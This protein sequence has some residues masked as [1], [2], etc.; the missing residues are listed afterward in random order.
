MIYLFH[1]RLPA[2]LEDVSKFPNLFAE[3]IKRKYSD[4]DIIKIARTNLL[5]VFKAVEKVRIIMMMMYI[6]M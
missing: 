2:E 6:F 4:S 3:L 5:R 1:F